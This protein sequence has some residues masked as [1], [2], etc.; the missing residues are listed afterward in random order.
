MKFK[1]NLVTMSDVRDFVNAVSD[2]S[3]EVYL[4]DGSQFCVSAHSLLGAMCS[5]E[6][7]ETWVECE[8]DIY[9]RISK[10]AV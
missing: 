7:K 9:N 8:E 2:I 3:N 4:K 10:W 5:V 6:W 1:I